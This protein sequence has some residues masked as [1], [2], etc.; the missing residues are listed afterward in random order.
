MRCGAVVSTVAAAAGSAAAG[1]ARRIEAPSGDD[2]TGPEATRPA[3]SP[4]VAGDRP[5]PLSG[6]KMKGSR[7]RTVGISPFMRCASRV[8]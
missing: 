7:G 3:R 5:I 4:N 2:S 8:R 6:S 1:W